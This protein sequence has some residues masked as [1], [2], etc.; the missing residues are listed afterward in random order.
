M[1]NLNN[2]YQTLTDAI[3]DIAP[4]TPDVALI[5]G[6]GLGEFANGS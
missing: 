3:K 4:F 2:K 5:L 1:I 6:S